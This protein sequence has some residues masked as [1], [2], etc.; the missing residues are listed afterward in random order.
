L[1]HSRLTA[2]EDLTRLTAD[3]AIPLLLHRYGA[4][5]YRLGLRVCGNPDDAHDL[6]QETLLNAYRKWEQ[7]E[8]RSAPSSWLYT[9]AVRACRRR[10]RRRSGEPASLRSLDELLPAGK[11][12][13]SPAAADNPLDAALAHEVEE[14]LAGA[15]AELPLPY[16][17]PLILKDIAELSIQEVAQILGL[18]EA[19]VKTRLHRARLQLRAAL[20]P[21][22][23]RRPAPPPDHPRSVCLDLL[24]AKQEALDRGVPYPVA[25]SELCTRC[26]ALFATL[27]LTHEACLRLGEGRLPEPVRQM[28]LERL[29]SSTT[30]RPPR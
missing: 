12:I 13:A 23:P 18:K 1:D 27:D 29:A 21:L 19:T 17:L 25:P 20:D 9:I 10:S 5:L 24:R 30:A 22:L 8:A 14:H 28:L 16:R 15:L 2:D 3:E 4:K 7:F 26:R 11:E 6:L